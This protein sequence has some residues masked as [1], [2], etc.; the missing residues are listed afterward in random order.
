[1][2][3]RARARVAAVV[4]LIVTWLLAISEIRDRCNRDRAPSRTIVLPSIVSVG[5][6]YTLPETPHAGKAG[7]THAPLF[8]PGTIGLAS[9]SVNGFA[10]WHF[11]GIE[12]A[13]RS[14]TQSLLF[15]DRVN[16]SFK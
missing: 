10:R 9:R 16:F 13:L 14:G 12:S 1:M 8:P 15:M 2:H 5:T 7:R 11:R 4:V 3:A 6:L